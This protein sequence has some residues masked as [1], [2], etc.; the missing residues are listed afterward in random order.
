VPSCQFGIR[1]GRRVT[2]LAA[3]NEPSSRY[4]VMTEAGDS[5]EPAF[6]AGPPGR[7]SCHTTSASSELAAS[8]L[9]LVDNEYLTSFETEADGVVV[10]AGAAV[11]WRCAR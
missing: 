9:S 3:P 7:V 1:L 8:R 4:L 11:T 5:G 10:P 2:L 6:A